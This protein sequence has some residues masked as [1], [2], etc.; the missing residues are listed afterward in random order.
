MH[1]SGFK[2]L[3]GC[4]VHGEHNTVTGDGTGAGTGV[5]LAVKYSR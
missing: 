3:Q 1:I 4:D 2:A 5:G